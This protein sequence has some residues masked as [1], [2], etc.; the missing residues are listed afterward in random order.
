MLKLAGSECHLV[1]PDEIKKLNPL[2]DTNGVLMGAFTP[3]DGHTDPSGITNAM[4]AG[5]KMH[6]VKSYVTTGSPTST[7]WRMGNGKW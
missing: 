7:N 6:G 3:N 1:G 4:A 2:L 5:A